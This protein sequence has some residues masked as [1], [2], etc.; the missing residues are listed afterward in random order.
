MLRGFQAE[1]ADHSAGHAPVE[2]LSLSDGPP[3]DHVEIA[4]SRFLFSAHFKKAGAD[5]VL[6]GDDGHKLV[7][8]DYFNLEKRPDLTSHGATLSADL[9]THLAG[10]DAPGQY[11]QAGAPAGGQVIGKCERVGGGA[12]VQHANGVTE[13]LKAND[14]VLKGDVVMTNDGSSAVLSLTDGT[15]FNMGASA[16]MVLSDL[17]YDPNSTSNSAVVSLVKGTFSFVAGHVAR[18]GDMKLDTPVAT[19]GIRG[20]AGTTTVNADASGTVYE[21]N[22]S[23]MP[24]P[25][26]HVGL[27]QVLDRVTGLVIGTISTTA[28]VLN[29]QPTANFQVIAQESPKAAAQ[30]AAE[31]AAAQVLY[32]AYQAV[33]ATVAAPPAPPAPT[34]PQ[35]G[36]Q[37][38][39]SPPGGSL[40]TQS[41]TGP[42]VTFNATVSDSGTVTVTKVTVDPTPATPPSPTPT[43]PNPPT[44][45]PTPTDP[46]PQTHGLT[47][48]NDTATAVGGSQGTSGNLFANDSNSGS[49]SVTGVTADAASDDTFTVDGTY[50]TL[51]VHKD[52]SYTY[53]L[54]AT[55]AERDL[56]NGLHGQLANDDFT[57][58]VSDGSGGTGTAEL[59]VSVASPQVTRIAVPGSQHDGEHPGAFNAIGPSI[60]ADGRHVVFIGSDALPT[61]GTGDHHGSD[62]YLYDRI[63]KDYTA[64]TDSAHIPNA[65]IGE[66]YDGLPSISDDGRYVVFR[67]EHTVAGGEL[68]QPGDQFTV[69]SDAA[70]NTS[71]SVAGL[72]N[73]N[74]V[75]VWNTEDGSTHFQLF[76]NT[77]EHIGSPTDVTDTGVGVPSSVAALTNNEF[78]VTWGAL[79]GNNAEIDG[80]VYDANGNPVE[81]SQF[82]IVLPNG[83][84]GPADVGTTKNSV[85]G[86][87]DGG[88]VV[89]FA[90][91][92]GTIE[93][94]Q[95]DA[96][97]HQ[98]GDPIT[99]SQNSNSDQAPVVASL[100]NGE[101]VVIW[102]RFDDAS[103]SGQDVIGRVFGPGGNA[104]GDE[105]LIAQNV[106]S[107][108]S[109]YSVTGLSKDGFVVTW[110]DAGF[111]GSNPS[112]LG[113]SFDNNGN[114]RSDVFAV[115]DT[116]LSASSNHVTALE[117]DSFAVSWTTV[118][119]NVNE[120]V[121]RAFDP[122]GT[123]ITDTLSVPI[124][125]DGT[126]LPSITT[127]ANGELAASWLDNSD[128]NV[129]AEMI[130]PQLATQSDIYLYN[131][132]TDQVTTI[133][134][135]QGSSDDP[136]L[137]GGG[138][139]IVASTN[140]GLGIA[141]EIV[142]V[143]SHCG[144][145]VLD[146]AGKDACGCDV[147]LST[148]AI[149]ALG[150]VVTFW[151]TASEID[152]GNEHF[153]VD[154][155][156]QAQVYAYNLVTGRLE[157]VSAAV[158]PATGA[159][160]YG[161]GNSGAL[162]V[163]PN[164][165]G[166]N[167]SD[168]SWASSISAD[169]RYVVFQST[170]SNLAPGDAEF[171]NI[172]VKDL[173][174]GAVQRV[175]VGLGNAE[176]DG[177]SIRPQISPD[178]RYV[179]FTSKADN[180]VAGDINNQFDAFI[181][182]T[183]NKTTTLLSESALLNL[184]N[185]DSSWG[186][187][188]AAGGIYGVFGSTAGNLT[189]DTT[190]GPASIYLVDTSGGTQGTVVSEDSVSNL[191][192][193]GT[194]AFANPFSGD[195]TL[196]VTFS[197]ATGSN[198]AGLSTATLSALADTVHGDFH[199]GFVDG[200]GLP[201]QWTFSAPESQFAEL[202]FGQTET[203]VYTL[204]L[205]GSDPHAPTVT[206][207]VTVTVVGTA[208]NT[209][210]VQ[211]GGLVF[212]SHTLTNA[213]IGSWSI[214]GGQHVQAPSYQ[215]AIEDFQ[216]QKT[217]LEGSGPPSTI[218]I[219]NDQF[220]GTAPP[221]AP[222]GSLTYSVGGGSFA[223][224]TDANGN[225]AVMSGQNAGFAGGLTGASYG[226]FA[227]LLTN[228]TPDQSQ[229]L[230]SGET[231][232]V[233]G[234]FDLFTPGANQSYGIRFS[235]RLTGTT[236]PVPPQ[237][238]TETLELAVVRDAST[239]AP[240]VQ[241]REI[242]FETGQSTVLAISG[243]LSVA[244]GDLI[245][246]ELDHSASSN[247]AVSASYQIIHNGQA[248]QVTTLASNVGAIF[249]NEDWTRAQFF[250][251]AQAQTTNATN[252]DTLLKGQYGTLDLK[253]NGTWTYAL[254]EG[255]ANVL[256]L[257]AGQVVHDIFKAT[258]AGV[259]DTIDVTVIGKNDPPTIVGDL[260]L[261]M[262]KG[263][264]VAL[265]TVDLRAVDPDN[266]ACELTF[267]AS[268]VQHG[269]LALA[270]DPSC[271]ITGF[272]EAQL[273][274]GQ[275]IFVHDGS[276]NPGSFAVQVTDGSLTSSTVTVNASLTQAEANLWGE[277]KFPSV[278]PGQHIFT[279]NVQFNSI[280]GFVA[281]GFAA[282]LN[283]DP[284][285]D[286]AGPYPRTQ[287]VALTDP[288]LLP[289]QPAT[290][291]IASNTVTL[292]ARMFTITPNL[293]GPEAIVASV[294]QTNTNNG[295]GS[296]V[297]HRT[298]ISENSDG[299]LHQNDLGQVGSNTGATI[300]NLTESYRTSDNTSSGTL[301]N[302]DIAWDPYNST[303]HTYQVYF[304]TFN[305]DNS[306]SAQTPV[307]TGIS[308]TNVL[309]TD[310]L[311]AWE[312]R[313][314]FGG[315]A[316]A[317]PV[318]A[319][320]FSPATISLGLTGQT[321]QEIHFQGYNADGT[322]NST[323]ANFH[324]ILPN[325]SAHSG[326]TNT[327]TQQ[328]VPSLGAYP[329]QTAAQ[330][331]FVQASSTNGGNAVGVAWNEKVTYTDNSNVTHIYDQVEFLV[332]KSNTITRPTVGGGS[333]PNGVAVISNG[334]VQNIRLGEFSDPSVSGRDDF[335]LVYGD[336]T[337]TH[338]NV[339]G[340][341]SGGTV[342]TPT[343]IV[344]ITDPTTHAFAN[345]QVLGD[346]RIVVT[347]DNQLAPDQTSQLDFKIFDLRTAPVTFDGQ[348]NHTGHDNYIAG[349][350]FDGDSVTGD[351]NQNNTY[352]FVGG[353][354]APHDF[355]NGHDNSN[356]GWN[357]AILSDARGSYTIN[358]NTNDPNNKL[359][360][361]NLGDPAHGGTLT[362]DKFVNALA[363][364]PTEDP[365]PGNN[366]G[367]VHASGNELLILNDVAKSNDLNHP[368]VQGFAIGGT[369]T[370]EFA[371]GDSNLDVTFSG[372]GG[373]LRLDQPSN[374]AATVHGFGAD[375]IDFVGVS[376]FDTV[377]VTGLTPNSTTLTLFNF[378]NTADASITLAGN[379]SSTSFFVADD[380]RGNALLGTDHAPQASYVNVAI[381]ATLVHAGTGMTIAGDLLAHFGTDP[382]S[383]DQLSLVSVD[384][385][386][387]QGQVYE[388]QSGDVVYTPPSG[389]VAP[390]G[391]VQTAAD[392]F[393]F[394]LADSEGLTSTGHVALTAQGGTQIVGTTGHDLIMGASG[395]TLT[396]MG[397]D[398]VFA[399][400]G[401]FGSQTI[402]DFHQGA[403][404]VDLSAFYVNQTQQQAAQALQSLIDATTAGSHTLALDASH[405]VTFQGVDVHQLN[406]SNDFILTHA[407]TVGA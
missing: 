255:Q 137:S 197:S 277:V 105:F 381:D 169:G 261:T 39:N 165:F 352:Y 315:Y 173:Q 293:N 77:G 10:P 190:N 300:F 84:P 157:A 115:S 288:F 63:T 162:S 204:T 286:P 178:G 406:A 384:G 22:F 228:I 356:H 11:A 183:W 172:F 82:S 407:H 98:N 373:T 1:S 267:T 140:F 139:F 19:M 215:F 202:Q 4:D 92:D 329:G 320:A 296:D 274:A 34:G 323:L 128:G 266:S 309:T 368:G 283:Y 94:Q 291:Q 349:T 184:G 104:V 402:S 344:S 57:Y 209:G 346:G 110:N 376:S 206:Q 325:L 171:S 310:G 383:G 227:T 225:V 272:T 216:V 75:S 81:D 360:I 237:P 130:N 135:L 351:S 312:F 148:P 26:G 151:T 249:D 174:T 126:S 248:G 144:Q 121:V 113:E 80:Q 21:V 141:N 336:D 191:S 31:L 403:D 338:I 230:R 59:T 347:Y 238:G 298:V 362:I 163:T 265:T 243:D 365:T 302:Y 150:H 107:D 181:Y 330:L 193:T 192:T 40:N 100:A 343:P 399:F 155:S 366:G 136:K 133:P 170:A 331:Q 290:L 264:T 213:D 101:F 138:N 52:G 176:P 149:D 377:Q 117:D 388:S 152:I 143:D 386:Q 337:G 14:A 240:E 89:T 114:A 180:L 9:V 122:I 187:A 404:H 199:A 88:F 281:L 247:H 397:G 175:S 387:T 245:K 229:G 79:N 396:G 90:P 306:A 303:T 186:A 109:S 382:D 231:F 7:L 289:D 401:S 222:E 118:I 167:N 364:A 333:D 358:P 251:V 166:N 327:I 246:L 116:E 47:L 304:Q 334:N 219:F 15:V 253:Q 370:L 71:A 12:T 342:V 212:T 316:L 56:L 350:S 18:T 159:T 241:L 51:V 45:T 339:Y 50:G 146:I 263:G 393:S 24:D 205:A 185:G 218:T 252:T 207:N 25:D 287:H 328:I 258:A 8:V 269:H 214:V 375:F 72:T 64:L 87:P 322:L 23:L 374:F 353:P 83:S 35:G 276:S 108:P 221:S 380:G 55:S 145:I 48:A 392:Q 195:A 65:P 85:T 106:S 37:Q 60:S 369:A 395:D 28:N 73:G 398:D 132:A 257:Q 2:R 46:G 372:P 127:L 220:N 284:V 210:A 357:T 236:A 42:I 62:V 69:T 294:T 324:D 41:Q 201:V 154:T 93:A 275:V 355:F 254:A 244:S 95:F 250:G 278:V 43:P 299:T 66:N 125:P 305:A 96:G 226:Q 36:Q 158:D 3:P 6:T 389:F 308:L 111:N 203:I 142:V 307:L 385:S 179:I 124:T 74:W 273:E 242:N 319:S 131:V 27:I 345:M 200:D 17:I 161:N 97:G 168:D 16:R 156:G 33:A 129:V 68:Q 32:P 363:F 260:A 211:D 292:P 405:T 189:G 53:T 332:D 232:S 119:G 13:E 318:S 224:G 379:Y 196:S 78:V 317:S 297:I 30:V 233:S 335:V 38:N 367:I 400:Q 54:G 371:H 340:V 359:D 61:P 262:V 311:P 70:A 271:A 198:G 102:S 295:S 223:S 270:S 341:S 217:T 67:G 160:T 58:T 49:L 86:L 182:D 120:V 282:T 44:P 313:S 123:P 279:P 348:N 314:G 239:G 76:D 354:T 208:T 234:K 91:G 147:A 103:P 390:T 164:N 177:Q 391:L 259:T 134:S 29:V 20:T 321:Y 5:L 256:A 378:S 112:V 188:V 285:N 301:Q 153:H 99:V 235:D 394:T 194:I 280:G 361:T 326:A 268:N